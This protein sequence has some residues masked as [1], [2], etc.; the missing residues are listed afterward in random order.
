MALPRQLY[1]LVS[2]NVQRSPARKPNL[3]E[4]RAQKLREIETKKAIDRAN[5]VL[6]KLEQR[7]AHFDAQIQVVRNEYLRPLEQRRACAERR[8][9]RLHDQVLAKL[10]DAN[11]ERADGFCR[12]FQA[13][14]CP[15]A[16]QVDNLSLLPAEYIRQKPEADKIAIKCALERDQALAIP[17]VRLTQKWRLVRK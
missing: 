4:L 13:V 16:V 2:H 12:E 14:P 1:A 7:L 5:E 17:G 3:L 15:K 9:A 6:D 8:I 11:L 10:S